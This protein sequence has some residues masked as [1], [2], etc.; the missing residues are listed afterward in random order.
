[1]TTS[2]AGGFLFA[3]VLAVVLGG[4]TAWAWQASGQGTGLSSDMDGI[5]MRDQASSRTR[6]GRVY[7][8]GGLRGG[9]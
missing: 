3:L 6:G 5:S 9:K 4:G 7:V 8:G 1:M 2:K